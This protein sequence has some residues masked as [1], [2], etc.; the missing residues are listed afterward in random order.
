MESA[1]AA[2]VAQVAR[3]ALELSPTGR[4]DVLVNNAGALSLTSGIFRQAIVQRNRSLKNSLFYAGIS[5]RGAILDV[6]VTKEPNVHETMMRV[7]H[8]SHVCLP[9]SSMNA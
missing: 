8:L 2:Q 4:V 7:N 6:D 9:V 3:A 5:F 1:S